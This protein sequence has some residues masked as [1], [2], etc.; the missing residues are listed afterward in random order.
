MKR[1]HTR[2]HGWTNPTGS[3][4]DAESIPILLD[5]LNFQS[6]ISRRGWRERDLGPCWSLLIVFF[7]DHLIVLLHQRIATI[8]RWLLSVELF[9]LGTNITL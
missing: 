4:F 1:K 8:G 3:A 2:A 9:E 5:S 6:N 7:F